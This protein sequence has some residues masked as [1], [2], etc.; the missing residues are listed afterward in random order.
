M[1]PA[2]KEDKKPADDG[3]PSEH[4]LGVREAGEEEHC[5]DDDR[6]VGDDRSQGS[7][8]AGRAAVTKRLGYDEGEK[9]SGGE[10]R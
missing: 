10:S 7:F 3:E 5:H 9:R 8:D 2:E 1:S 6:D 4:L